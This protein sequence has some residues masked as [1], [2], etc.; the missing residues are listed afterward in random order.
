MVRLG[1]EKCQAPL[2]LRSHGGGRGAEGCCALPG[3][4]ELVKEGQEGMLRSSS[5]AGMEAG[6]ERAGPGSA[7]LAGCPLG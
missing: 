3:R 2:A 7:S 6:G 4:K 1:L 5:Q